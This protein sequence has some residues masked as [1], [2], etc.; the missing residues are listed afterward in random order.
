MFEHLWTPYRMAYIRGEGKPT[1]VADC[2]FCVIPTMSDED[3]L[4]VARGTTV[5]AVLNLY[6][7]NAG[8]LML[9]PYRHVPEASPTCPST[10]SRNSALFT[11]TAMRVI[12]S[13]SGGARVQHRDEPGLGRR[14]RASPTT[15]TS[16]PYRAG[17]ATPTSC[18]SSVSRGC[19]RRSWRR[20]G[21][22][23]PTWTG[24][25]VPRCVFG[26][27]HHRVVRPPH[28]RVVRPP[29]HPDGGLMLGLYARPVVEKVVAPLVGGWPARGSPPTW[30]PPSASSGALAGAVLLFGTGHL[31]WGTVVV[32]FWVLLDLLDGA[33]ARARGGGSVFG[34]VLDFILDRAADAAD[35]RGAGLVVLRRRRQPAAPAAALL[36]LVLGV[37][38]SYMKARAEGVGITCDVGIVERLERLMLACSASGWPAWAFP[39]HCTSRSGCCSSAAPSP[40][41]SASWGP[42][43]CAGAGRSAQ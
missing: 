29:H 7:Y 28:H 14:R 2:P 8:H 15:C 38:T 27:P 37:L 32:T 24:A 10:R 30:S 12:R 6:P 39:W 1:G 35:V 21:R 33:L 41:G 19:C 16:T 17:A 3:G 43:G 26:P 34:A 20:P 11:Q 13:V 23:S 40:S 9:V 5:Y 36:A 42:A 18:R 22:C 25:A 31:F 4:V